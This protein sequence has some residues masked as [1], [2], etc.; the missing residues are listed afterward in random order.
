LK[1]ASTADRYIIIPMVIT[2]TGISDHL[3]T[4]PVIT[5]RRIA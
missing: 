2:I 1:T 5:F 3:P 4:E